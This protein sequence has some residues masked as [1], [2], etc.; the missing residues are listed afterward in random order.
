MQISSGGI[1]IQD[2]I[3]IKDGGTIGIIV[4]DVLT[5]ASTGIVTFKDDIIIK[6]AAR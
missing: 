6:D 4:P 2:D 1:V 3:L 5:L